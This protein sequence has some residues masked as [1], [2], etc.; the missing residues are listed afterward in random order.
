MALVKCTHL[1]GASPAPSKAKDPGR[2]LC[3]EDPGNHVSQAFH[4]AVQRKK[5]SCPGP[6]MLLALASETL[7][8]SE[9]SL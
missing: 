3:P 4:F 5:E 1:G 2:H 7:V 9:P 6:P 8:V